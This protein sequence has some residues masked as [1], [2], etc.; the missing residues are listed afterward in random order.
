MA[1]ASGST[2]VSKPSSGPQRLLWWLAGAHARLLEDE[3]CWIERPRYTA[4]GLAVAVTAIVAAVGMTGAL[5]S[6]FPR[7]GISAHL[8]AGVLW[9]V[10]ILTVD[11][12]LLLGLY[13]LSNGKLGVSGWGV[14]L[15]I[16]GAGLISVV[17]GGALELTVFKNEIDVQI[18]VERERDVAAQQARID[19]RYGRIADIA[20]ERRQL[21]AETTAAE[22][23]ADAARQAAVDE[24][25]GTGGSGKKG[26]D[27]I[28]DIKVARAD[29]LA[30]GA[31]NVA[32]RNAARAAALDRELSPLEAARSRDLA[33]F[34]ERAAAADGLLARRA[35]LARIEADPVHGRTVWLTGWVVI[36]ASLF[37]ELMPLVTK[38][39]GAYGPYDAAYKAV[40]D[41]EA[42]RWRATEARAVERA[43]AEVAQ[44]AA[45]TAAGR[46][47]GEA[48]L[49][50]AVVEAVHSDA[51]RAAKAAM[52][53]E[54]IERMVR[55]M[56][57]ASARVFD[58]HFDDDVTAAAQAQRQRA[59]DDVGEAAA[60]R[61][62][63]FA[64]MDDA[65]RAANENLRSA[66]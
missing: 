55:A 21:K 3:S 57:R 51:A 13:K 52:V 42:A 8:A 66:S 53:S 61:G 36:L 18:A 32:G 5:A 2:S 59:A 47:A 19:S 30:A 46:A 58:G 26:T 17:I 56:R 45:M 7:A 60:A 23:A 44:E 28:Y 20:A 43:E 38:L 41:G 6:I 54:L 29:A 63:A 24:A 40:K 65:V 11:R 4:A 37:V 62:A 49:A 39:T 25:D 16:V 10:I 22:A 64:Q 34:Q 9:G 33:A 14:A 50:E 31:A 12:G 35:A 15:R 48:I 1:R 27:E